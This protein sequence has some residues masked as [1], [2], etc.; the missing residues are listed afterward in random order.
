MLFSIVTW[1]LFLSTH[2]VDNP[3]ISATVR[4]ENWISQELPAF[5][6]EQYKCS[7]MF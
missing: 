6:S 3:Y 7:V 5:H 2:W 1:T 4:K